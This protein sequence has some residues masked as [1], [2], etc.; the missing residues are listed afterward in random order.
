MLADFGQLVTFTPGTAYPYRSD[1]TVEIT[2]IFDNGF[3]AVAGDEADA[4]TRQ[5]T[6]LCRTADTLGAARNS[7]VEIGS[8]VYKVVSPEPDGTGMTLLVLEGPK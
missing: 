8:D 3:Y 5:P 6:L 2:G 7:M 1:K 4:N